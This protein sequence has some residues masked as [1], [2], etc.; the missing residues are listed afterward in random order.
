MKKILL[1]VII[2]SVMFVTGCNSEITKNNLNS[3]YVIDNGQFGEETTINYP[4]VISQAP[5]YF[6]NDTIESNKTIIINDVE[7]ELKYRDTLYYPVGSKQVHRYFVNGDENKK[8]LLDNYGEINS[9]LFK[10]ATLEISKNATSSEVLEL[11][12]PELAKI[13]DITFYKDI[14]MPQ[15]S[16]NTSGFGI[17]DYK[18]YNQKNGYI[19][20]YL[21]VSISSEDGSVFG[22]K[23]NNLSATN[24]ELDI[25]KEKEKQAIDL[26]LKDI[27]SITNIGE[28]ISYEVCFPPMVKE[29]ENQLYIMHFVSPK[30]MSENGETSGAIQTLLIPVELISN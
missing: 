16:S 23:I 7:W 19:T 11:L 9:I 18:F 27:V 2:L 25:N 3:I 30:Y 29:Y 14:I 26:K 22:L 8:V 20:D 13:V 15:D 6:V 17:Y 1:I 5:N 10:F 21:N 24:I 12:K 4:N 28:Y